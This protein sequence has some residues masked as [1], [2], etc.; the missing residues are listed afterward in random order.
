MDVL[1]VDQRINGPDPHCS[2]PPGATWGH[3]RWYPASWVVAMAT[4]AWHMIQRLF[5]S[6]RVQNYEM[7][8]QSY[9]CIRTYNTF[10]SIYIFNVY[11]II[12]S[13]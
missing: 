2:G 11:E 9:R 3:L 5:F 13:L 10:L 4:L 7:T 8:V 6:G 12:Y 1:V